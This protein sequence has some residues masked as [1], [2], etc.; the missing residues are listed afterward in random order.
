MP[1]P[2]VKYM[3]RSFTIK[4]FRCFRDLTIEP[5]ARVNLIAGKN[6]VGK[7]A[8]LEA[9][10]LHA[11]ANN[12]QLPWVLSAH[13]GIE[14]VSTDPREMWGW[15]FYGKRTEQ[16]IELMSFGPD[17]L[18]QNLSISLKEPREVTQYAPS[19]G[20]LRANGGD[21]PAT[22]VP[23]LWATALGDCLLVLTYEDTSGRKSSASAMVVSGEKGLELRLTHEGTYLLPMA[24]FMPTHGRSAREDSAIFSKMVEVGRD[25]ELLLTLRIL[26]PRLRRLMVLVANGV[27]IV[28]GDVGAGAPVPLPLMG[29][30]VARLLS[31]LLATANAPGGTVMVDEIENGLHYSTLVDI[32]RAIGEAAKRSDTQI[33]ATTHSWE[34]IVAAHE[35][36]NTNGRDTNFRLFRL[37][38]LDGEIRAVTYDAEMLGASFATGLEVR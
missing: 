11:G 18:T 26:D 37:D 1:L 17:G 23:G 35:A 28:H 10:L 19:T 5:L 14:Q 34:C 33:F 25:E 21:G 4:N 16:E 24:V 31:L 8:L 2:E 32:W 15:L 6:N 22:V 38:R 29:A 9:L 27:P 36:F 20:S 3:F 7:T 13:R 12:P 30:G